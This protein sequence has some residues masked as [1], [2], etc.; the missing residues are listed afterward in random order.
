VAAVFQVPVLRAETEHSLVVY[1]P[2]F[3]WAM[4]V[5]DSLA[6]PVLSCITLSFASR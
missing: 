2:G 6:N 1:D 4:A 5:S 3:P